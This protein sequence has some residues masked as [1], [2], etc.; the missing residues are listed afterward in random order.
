MT[1][2]RFPF[3]L[4]GIAF[5]HD[6]VMAALSLPLSLWLRVGTGDPDDTFVF[7]APATSLTIRMGGLSSN[8]LTIGAGGPALVLPGGLSVFGGGFSDRVFVAGGLTLARGNF[9]VNAATGD[10]E[11]GV[12]GAVTV[13]DGSFTI[14]DHDDAIRN[15]LEFLRS[16]PVLPDDLE[17][18][19]FVYD[20]TTGRLRAI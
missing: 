15:D 12:N 20:V 18:V 3:N 8:T 17:I 14:D 10:T 2:R 13:S 4:G 19:G 16:S 7:A 9:F 1:A 6:L 11:I 5:L